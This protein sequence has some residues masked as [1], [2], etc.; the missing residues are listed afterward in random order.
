MVILTLM[1]IAAPFS[2]QRFYDQVT[3]GIA[4]L[5][6]TPGLFDTRF[7]IGLNYSRFQLYPYTRESHGSS[8]FGIRGF[9]LK[10][11]LDM[12][13]KA[14]GY[15][16]PD[17]RGLMG[18]GGL[19]LIFRPAPL[20]IAV[21]MGYTR[22]GPGKFF[23][24]DPNYNFTYDGIDFLHFSPILVRPLGLLKLRVRARFVGA[25]FAGR[26]SR[27]ITGYEELIRGW[28]YGWATGLG[29]EFK[30]W[31]VKPG[32]IFGWGRSGLEMG[33]YIGR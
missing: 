11:W 1:L 23:P 25:R 32:L 22:T 6:S 20:Q 4:Q 13:V 28:G 12:E 31:G 17:I 26:F 18:F 15:S 19:D 2:A 9:R 3:P 33:F 7:T 8:F 24:G 21:Q 27:D 16:S 10:D 29:L 5:T 14:G 30:L